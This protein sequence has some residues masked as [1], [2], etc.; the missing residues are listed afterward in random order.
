[1]R[2]SLTPGRVGEKERS[3]DLFFFYILGAARPF[4]FLVEEG[5]CFLFN[6]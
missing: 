6:R 4:S 3:L 1:M 5:L 2:P